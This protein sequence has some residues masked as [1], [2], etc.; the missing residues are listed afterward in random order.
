MGV[1]TFK[2]SYTYLDPFGATRQAASRAASVLGAFALAQLWY[3][4]EGPVHDAGWVV[5]LVGQEILVIGNAIYLLESGRMVRGET[6]CDM[7][8]IF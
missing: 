7:P 2:R 3:D 4:A 8:A 5:L 1:Q 6:H